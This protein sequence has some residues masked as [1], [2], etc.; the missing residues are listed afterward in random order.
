MATIKTRRCENCCP[1]CGATDSDIEWGKYEF[2]AAPWQYA[3]CKKCGC[4]FREIYRYSATE[5]EA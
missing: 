3:V 2:D 4:E 5:W 1:E